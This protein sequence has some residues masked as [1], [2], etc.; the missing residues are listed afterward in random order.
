MTIG[1]SGT[2]DRFYD[3]FSGSNVTAGTVTDYF[4]HYVKLPA[5]AGTVTNCY[6]YYTEELT[7][8]A[9]LNYAYYSAGATPSKFEGVHDVGGLKVGGV[10]ATSAWTVFT[11]TI[12]ANSGA[13]TSVTGSGRYRQFGKTVFFTMLV[14]ITTNGTAAGFI[15]AT[16]PTSFRQASSLQYAFPGIIS[17]GV[18]TVAITL[19]SGPGNTI[20][21]F[22]YDGSYPGSSGVGVYVSGS[23]EAA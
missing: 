9:S 23:Y 21:I 10:D 22:K 14:D 15:I 17:G 2:S 5:G 16:L 11:P 20:G 13:F 8:G 3:F 18:T 7:K 6:G 12:S 4:S 19:G 1:S